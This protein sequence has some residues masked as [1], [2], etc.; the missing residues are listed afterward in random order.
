MVVEMFSLNSDILTHIP[1]EDILAGW[2]PQMEGAG[3]FL[4]QQIKDPQVLEKIKD[5]YDNFIES[6]QVWALVIGFIF[7]YIF[8]TFTGY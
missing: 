6:G 8:R 5:A 3:T 1:S 4:A 7:G 2:V